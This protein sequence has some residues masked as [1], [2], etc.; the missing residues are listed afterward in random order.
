MR[1]VLKIFWKIVM[2]FF[3]FMSVVTIFSQINDF[4]SGQFNSEWLFWRCGNALAISLCF[5]GRI[6]LIIV[7]LIAPTMIFEWLKKP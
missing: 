5:A 7:C 1:S 4:I 2:A 6:P 3:F